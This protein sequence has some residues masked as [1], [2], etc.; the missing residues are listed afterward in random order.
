MHVEY[1]LVH[2]MCVLV[3]AH[4]RVL[5]GVNVNVIMCILMDTCTCICSYAHSC[6]CVADGGGHYGGFLSIIIK[7]HV[8]YIYENIREPQ[9]YR[10][11]Q[12]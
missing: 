1:Q 9:L 7:S 12:A 11:P 3:H 8:E 4:V 2:V 10:L 5:V 6:G